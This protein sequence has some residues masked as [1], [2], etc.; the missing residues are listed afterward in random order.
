MVRRI[1]HIDDDADILTIARV[2]LRDLAGFEVISFASGHEALAR[3]AGCHPDIILLDV[4][5]PDLDGEALMGHLKSDPALCAVPVVLLTAKAQQH[6][7][8]RYR[9]S[10]AAGIIPK[11]FDPTTLAEQ[12]LAFLPARPK[13]KAPS[14]C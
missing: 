1:A 11:P 4:M 9:R 12:V 5:M 14:S 8:D 7:L 10:G 2:A 3:L 6:D 13:G